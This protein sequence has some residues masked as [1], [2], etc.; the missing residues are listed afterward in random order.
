MTAKQISVF[1]ENKP[2]QLAEFTKLLEKNQINMLAMAL[3]DAEDFGILRL[4]VD[5]SYQTACI[6]KDAGFVFSITPV[7]AVEIPNQPGSLVEILSVL[8]E[9][10]INV[11]YAYTFSV[12]KEDCAYIIF[13]VSDNQKAGEVLS[14]KGIHLFCQNDLA[15]LL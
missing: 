10:Q 2:G 12:K 5:D 11:E 1:L 9:N 8:G 13:R 7:L 15:S 4:I 6:L 14:K 3:A